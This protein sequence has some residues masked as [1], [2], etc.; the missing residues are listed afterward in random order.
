MPRMEVA[1]DICLRPRPTQGCIADDDDDDDDLNAI[2]LWFLNC[3]E[4]EVDHSPPSSCEAKNEWIST[5]IPLY[6]S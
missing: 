5:S 6:T 4:C 1:G 3:A 2:L